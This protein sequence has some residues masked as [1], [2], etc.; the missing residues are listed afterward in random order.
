MESPDL[1]CFICGEELKE[2]PDDMIDNGEP[3]MICTDEECDKENRVVNSKTIEE[4]V[5]C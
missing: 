4:S 5:K 3:I 2:N 1:N